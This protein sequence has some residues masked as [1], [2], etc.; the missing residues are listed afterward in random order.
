MW[1]QQGSA[2]LNVVAA[3]KGSAALNVVAAGLGIC[4]A[5]CGCSEKGILGFE[6]K[7]IH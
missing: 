6:Q 1:L 5:K 7:G 2:T 4:S 3:G